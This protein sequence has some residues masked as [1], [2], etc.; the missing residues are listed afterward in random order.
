MGGGGGGKK[1]VNGKNVGI[2]TVTISNIL[3]F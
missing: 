3:V 2:L 1:S